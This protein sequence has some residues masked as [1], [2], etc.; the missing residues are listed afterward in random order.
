MTILQKYIFFKYLY[1]LIGLVFL[2]IGLFIMLKFT[3]QINLF[4]EISDKTL[5]SEYVFFFLYEIPFTI[6]YL[7]PMASLFALVYTLGKLNEDNELIVTYTGGRSI[8][9][10]VLPIFIFNVL[11][12]VFM[13]SYE[14]DFFYPFH[15]KHMSIYRKFQGKDF[16][17]KEDRVN[18]VQF[19]KDNKIYLA[20]HYNVNKKTL[21]S[22]NIVYLNDEQQFEKILSSQK[23]VHEKETDWRLN[24]YVLKEIKN[25]NEVGFTR[26]KK[27]TL[28]LGDPPSTFEKIANNARDLS[29]KESR[30]IAEKLEIIGGNSNKWWTDYHKKNAFLFISLT[31]FFLG[32]TLSTFSKNAILVLSFTY[33]IIL[34][35]LYMILYNVGASLGQIK[36]LPPVVAGWFGNI[37]FTIVSLILYYR[38][39]L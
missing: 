30:E 29:A 39:R 20:N 26:K 16:F 24:D 9:F 3:E 33:V 15:Q 38:I 11:F 31:M 21:T 25:N 4:I 8:W 2:F 7:F 10:N 5:F 18:L 35:F 34:A 37:I 19:G 23:I 27:E 6:T 13:L 22:A 14:D 12:C 32:V 17:R 1:F 36:L 28:N